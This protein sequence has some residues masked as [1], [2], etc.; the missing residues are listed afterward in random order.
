MFFYSNRLQQTRHALRTVGINSLL[1]SQ[2]SQNWI[3]YYNYIFFIQLHKQNYMH[4]N[5]NSKK[6][7]TS[8]SFLWNEIKRAITQ[9][10]SLLLWFTVKKRLM[11]ESSSSVSTTTGVPTDKLCEECTLCKCRPHDLLGRSCVKDGQMTIFFRA[12]EQVYVHRAHY[13]VKMLTEQ[14]NELTL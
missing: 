10:S 2:N 13:Y 8:I 14:L 3:R 12:S 5:F 11:L 6:I 4:F 7:Y 1:Y 9:R